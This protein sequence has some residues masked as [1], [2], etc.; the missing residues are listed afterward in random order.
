MT[1]LNHYKFF[2]KLIIVNICYSNELLKYIY[3][4]NNKKNTIFEVN[5][6]DD[7]DRIILNLPNTQEIF[8]ILNTSTAA[9]LTMD[10]M[11]NH[12]TKI[13]NGVEYYLKESKSRD[14]TTNPSFSIIYKPR[15]L[16]K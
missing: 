6:Y 5:F 9:M 14:L 13:L 7:A 15:N 3:C 8:G 10:L 11:A 1:I 4:I 2:I 16:N 12:H